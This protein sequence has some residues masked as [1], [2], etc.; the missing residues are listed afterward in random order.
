MNINFTLCDWSCCWNW[1]NMLEDIPYVQITTASNYDQYK[2]S[3]GRPRPEDIKYF[4][5]IFLTI[6]VFYWPSDVWFSVQV[7][8][9]VGLTIHVHKLKL[10]QNNVHIV[11]F[12]VSS[13]GNR[14]ETLVGK[15]WTLQYDKKTDSTNKNY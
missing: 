15:K 6:I 8:V 13:L 3:T 14:T 4:G 1:I 10:F 7:A 9:A 5:Y 11:F 2:L 12:E